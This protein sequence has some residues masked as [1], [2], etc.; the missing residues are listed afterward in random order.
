[1]NKK[2]QITMTS[3]K[4]KL[5]KSMENIKENNNNNKNYAIH[6]YRMTSL[7]YK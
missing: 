7:D 5:K 3:T 2:D 4:I 6:F 1:M